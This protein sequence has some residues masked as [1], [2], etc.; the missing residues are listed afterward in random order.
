MMEKTETPI[1]F[2]YLGG[3]PILENLHI[4]IV[5]IYWEYNGI[6]LGK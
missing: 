6:S 5:E 3:T 2:D 1:K 4:I